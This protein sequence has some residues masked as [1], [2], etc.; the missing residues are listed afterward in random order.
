[1]LSRKK[2]RDRPLQVTL[3]GKGARQQS[4][5]RLKSMWKLDNVQFGSYVQDIEAVWQTHHGLILPS[6]YEGLPLAVVEAMLCARPC[7]VTDVAGNRELIEDNVEGFIAAAPKPEFLDEALERAWQQRARWYDI[8]QAAAQKVR[9]CVPRDP[10]GAFA[11][12]LEEL[13]KT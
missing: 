10:I 3:Y 4:L 2:W 12:Q 8:G 13:I 6:R 7:I 11:Q 5:A 1:M 9:A